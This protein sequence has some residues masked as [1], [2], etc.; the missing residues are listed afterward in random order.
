M[1]I[2]LDISEEQAQEAGAI[3][4][5]LLFGYLWKL[6]HD[7]APVTL[8]LQRPK[9]AKKYLTA[10]QAA[11]EMGIGR[12]T[13]YR[14]KENDKQFPATH[15]CGGIEKYLASEIERYHLSRQRKA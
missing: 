2:N 11:H 13:F 4:G 1:N 14:L 5:A 8:P 12:S 3:C 15:D 7:S 10:K 6:Q 9:K